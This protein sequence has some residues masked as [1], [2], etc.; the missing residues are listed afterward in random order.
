MLPEYSL[1]VFSKSSMRMNLG[2][3]KGRRGKGCC[4]ETHTQALLSTLFF[5]KKIRIHHLESYI[6]NNLKNLEN[7]FLKTKKSYCQLKGVLDENSPVLISCTVNILLDRNVESKF[8]TLKIIT[9]ISR[10]GS[11]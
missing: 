3:I 6:Q 4:M 1:K 8:C 5:L 2:D 11:E 7:L 9:C 10:H